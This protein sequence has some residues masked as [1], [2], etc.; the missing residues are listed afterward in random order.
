M[1]IL[2]AEDQAELQLSM[3]LL[4]KGWGHNPDIVPNGQKALARAKE[5]RYDLCFMDV[6]MPIMDGLT[7]TRQIRRQSNYFPIIIFSGNMYDDNDKL[8]EL[9][10]DDIVRKP[11]N[12]EQLRMKIDEWGQIKT[13]LIS[14][15]NQVVE[16]RKE[17]PMDPQH[18]QELKE[19]AKKD[20]CKMTLKG[21]NVTLIVHKNVPNKISHD[22][23][24]KEMEMSTFLDRNS[25][26]PGE[27][28]LY[29]SS[30]LV[31]IV[32]FEEEQFNEKVIREEEE[33]K[34]YNKLVLKKKD[35]A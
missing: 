2:I 8:L 25:S 1:K 3:L 18:A 29:K 26:L 23:I 20:L 15:K 6:D 9:G 10:V 35:P 17:M 33:M 16:T 34:Q 11:C 19:L 31:P 5:N 14:V 12:P 7:A 21:Q 4:I 30:G 24:E 28:H 22:F 27:C 32:H 13:W